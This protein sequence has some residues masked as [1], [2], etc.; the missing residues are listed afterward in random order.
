MRTALATLALVCGVLTLHADEGANPKD[1]ARAQVLF[2]KLRS[3]EKPQD[4]PLWKEFLANPAAPALVEENLKARGRPEAS[5]A[6]A[7]KAHV[8]MEGL[9]S[10]ERVSKYAIYSP[11]EQVRKTARQSLKIMK[12]PTQDLVVKAMRGPREMGLRALDVIRDNPDEKGLYALVVAADS[13]GYGGG[14]PRSY[15]FN[16]VQQAYVQDVTAVV[17]VGVATFDPDI[18]YVSTGSVLDAKVLRTEDLR[19]TFY[20]VTGVRFDTPGKAQ[21]WWEAHKDEVLKRI[22][23]GEKVGKP[24]AP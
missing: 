15:I 7:L 8:E 11:S 19:R 4:S 9:Q 2:S 18:G 14:G 3:L 23:E 20:E 5:V 10:A 12:A 6:L 13:A 22:E 21:A 1:L 24:S 16:A 17:Q